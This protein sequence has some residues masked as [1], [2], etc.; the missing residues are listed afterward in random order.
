MHKFSQLILQCR[1][2]FE[3]ET[4]AE[5]TAC[6]ARAGVYGYCQLT[7]GQGYVSFQGSDGALL[8]QAVENLPFDELIYIRQ[9]TLATDWLELSRDDRVGQIREQLDG[10][11]ACAEV[12]VEYPDTTEG[13]ELATF[14]RKF[15]SALAQR[16][17]KDRWLRPAATEEKRGSHWRLQLFVLSGE[18]MALGI[19]PLANS[20]PWP[21]GILR[22]KFPRQAPSRSTLKLEEAWHWFVPREEW[23]TRLTGGRAVDLG[24]APGGWTWQLVQRGMFVSAVDNGP[25]NEDLME[26]GQVEHC[27][28]DGY[29]YT[30]VKPVDW[31]VCDMVDK[32]I[33]TAAMVVEWAVNGYC[34]EMI[35]NLKLP[36]KQRYKETERCL[37][38]IEDALAL[39]GLQWQLRARQLYHDREEI[40]CHLRLF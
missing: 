8:Q 27:R 35:F 7:E 1:A 2:G 5:I 39:A 6:L 25:M 3:K 26:S 20:A 32:P 28:E 19:A 29:V 18:R 11:P 9:W 24:A 10:V 4:A 36:M 38:H 34:R 37:Q 16:L 21:Q 23:D 33:R 30:P 22:L 13:R 12:W 17:K 31:M 14:C 15:G 40:T